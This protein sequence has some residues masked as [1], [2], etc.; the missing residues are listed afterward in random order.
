MV[1]IDAGARAD[2]CLF[3]LAL[4]CCAVIF[5]DRAWTVLPTREVY[6]SILVEAGR[7]GGAIPDIVARRGLSQLEW[8]RAAGCYASDPM[9]V[10]RVCRLLATPGRGQGK[11]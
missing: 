5:V 2:L 3:C 1:P 4:A 6:V 11:R 9:V 7:T 10:D 8:G